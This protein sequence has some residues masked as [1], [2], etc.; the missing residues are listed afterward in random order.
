MRFKTDDNI[1]T[2]P[3][4]GYLWIVDGRQVRIRSGS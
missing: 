1:Y 4:A 2:E 3:L